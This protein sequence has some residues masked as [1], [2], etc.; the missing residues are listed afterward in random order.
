[1]AGKRHKTVWIAALVPWLAFAVVVVFAAF[2]S[3]CNPEYQEHAGPKCEAD[4]AHLHGQKPSKTTSSFDVYIDHTFRMTGP[5]FPFVLLAFHLLLLP[6]KQLVDE[7]VFERQEGKCLSS[8]VTGWTSEMIAWCFS[9]FF[10][11]LSLYSMMK[12][13]NEYAS[14]HV[15]L[16]TSMIAQVQIIL[17]VALHILHQRQLSG[18]A[19][20]IVSL[21][22]TLLCMICLET[23]TTAKYYHTVQADFA[24]MATGFALFGTASFFWTKKVDAHAIRK[25]DYRGNMQPVDNYKVEPLLA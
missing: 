23:F 5:I 21:C 7:E 17:T 14:D 6:F 1:M 20:M 19:I 15:F 10:A 2:T 24:G 9:I 3:K 4:L 13:V 18:R 8:Q 25:I 11:R 12:R 22:I 16:A